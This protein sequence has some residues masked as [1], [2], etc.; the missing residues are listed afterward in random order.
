[1][2]NITLE[3]LYDLAFYRVRRI[4]Q[5][6]GVLLVY[7]RLCANVSTPLPVRFYLQISAFEE[8]SRRDSNS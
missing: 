8:W 1:M 2:P 7:S 4:Y 6:V 3:V 5:R